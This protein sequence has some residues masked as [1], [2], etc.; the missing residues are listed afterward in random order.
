ML[1]FSTVLVF[2]AMQF[3][4]PLAATHVELQ[5]MP[6]G[7]A[8]GEADVDFASFEETQRALKRDRAKMGHRYIELFA[9]PMNE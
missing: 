6:S 7:K 8:S 4:K 1:A 2:G 9:H 5:R 3:F